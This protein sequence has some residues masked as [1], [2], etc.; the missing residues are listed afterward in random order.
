MF[1]PG[2]STQQ[3]VR[4]SGVEHSREKALVA[5]VGGWNARDALPAM[6]PDHAVYLDNLIPD[7]LGVRL[8][9][10]M[11]THATGITGNFVESLM[12]YNVAG[13]S[14]KLFAAGPTAI[15][16]V[17]AEATATSVVSSLSNGRWQHTMFAT[18]GGN[19]LV[20]CNG[21]DSVRNYDGS[22]WTTPAITGVTSSTL[23]N[24]CTHVQRLFFVRTGTLKYYYLDALAIAGAASEVDLA[25]LCKHGGELVAMAS[26]SRDGG[27]GL[28]D[29]A[30]FAT[31]KGEILVYQ[32]IDPSTADTWALVGVFKVPEPVGRRCFIKLG[33]DLC[34]LSSQG[35]MPLP[36]F[37]GKSSAGISEI[38]VTDKISGA[39][40]DAYRSGGTLFGWQIIEYPK[41]NL[42]I[43]NVPIKERATQH[44]YV[45]NLKT[46]AWCRFKDINAGCWGVKGD[47]LF[48]GGND[49]K[50]REYGK[51]ATKYDDDGTAITALGVQAYNDFGTPKVKRFTMARPWI[52]G[53]AGYVPQ[54]RMLVDFST[55][56]PTFDPVSYTQIGEQWDEALW[57]VA[58]WASGSLASS[59]WQSVTGTSTVGAIAMAAQL[60]RSFHWNKTDILYEPGG[61]L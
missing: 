27:S 34:Y 24:V 50:V 60:T 52:T 29:Y 45:M 19:Y 8:R 32:G 61:V 56:L 36:Q 17:S 47:A 3:R 43:C 59:Y 21:A 35:V 26:W 38:A 40:K 28:D 10:G 39:F 9:R 5:P 6:K 12:E 51:T 54:V 37:L 44:Q 18:T 4:V 25:P 7:T 53:P 14:P 31:S 58:L 15:F 16:D 2:I 41:E 22:S 48:A 30:V 55:T 11:T 23:I 20:A 1:S 13:A 46:G 57:D 42:L 33:A 49:G